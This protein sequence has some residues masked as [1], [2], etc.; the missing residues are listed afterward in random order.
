MTIYGFPDPPG[1]LV[2]TIRGGE[3]SYFLPSTHLTK[4]GQWGFLPHKKT[5]KIPV[6]VLYGNPEKEKTKNDLLSTQ[7]NLLVG[8][9][10]T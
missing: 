3:K 5:Q 9:L 4:L 8:S 2:E 7:N 6:V 1:S 10:E